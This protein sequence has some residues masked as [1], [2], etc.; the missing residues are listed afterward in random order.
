LSDFA[1]VSENIIGVIGVFVN[2]IVYRIDATSVLLATMT[3]PDRGPIYAW[4]IENGLTQAQAAGVLNVPL[5]T[6][7]NW[8][9]N[10]RQPPALIALLIERLRPGD[11]PKQRGSEGRRPIG[12]FV[13]SAEGKRRRPKS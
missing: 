11:Y 2:R 12:V 6:L 3:K 4:R 9:Q 5:P 13:H 8:E 10:R 7:K 1:A